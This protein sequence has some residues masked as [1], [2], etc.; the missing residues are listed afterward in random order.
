MGVYEYPQV[1][2]SSQTRMDQERHQPQE[3][4]HSQHSRF[5]WVDTPAEA[6][7]YTWHRD[8]GNQRPP[9]VPPLPQVP[10]HL[11]NQQSHSNPDTV[12]RALE[13]TGAHQPQQPHQP[14]VPVESAPTYT[15]SEH[16]AAQHYASGPTSYSSQDHPL[17]YPVRPHQQHRN[18]QQSQDTKPENTMQYTQMP[19]QPTNRDPPQHQPNIPI[20]PD[21]NPLSPTT[22]TKQQHHPTATTSNTTNIPILAPSTDS[23]TIPISSFS[24]TPQPI[25]GGTWH[26]SFCSCAEPTICLTA[27]TC[28]CITYGRTQYRLTQRSA[29]RD[30]TNMLGYTACNGSC[31][32]FGL[33][34]GINIVLAAIQ[35]TRVRKAYELDR[36]LTGGVLE[37]LLKAACCCCC[38]VAQDEKEVQWREEEGRKAKGAKG[39]KGG[40]QPTVADGYVP[41]GGMAFSPPPR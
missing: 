23:S 1:P 27:L 26:H 30:P 17:S 18:Q 9:N 29:R 22:P 5:S 4:T 36:K 20:A 25:R 10:E 16:P 13:Q 7:G 2:R 32:A 34:C 35:K 3:P 21:E 37:D 6:K 41:V 15:Q 24:P 12:S 11:Q 8:G 38:S 31:V 33:L 19:P 28:P 40:R 14:A 39:A